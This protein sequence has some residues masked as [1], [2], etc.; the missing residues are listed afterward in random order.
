MINI[1]EN[2]SLAP[3][4]TFR[5]GGLAKYFIEVNNKEELLEALGFVR[6][7]QLKYFILGGGSNLLI[8]DKGFDGVVIKIKINEF[9]ID[10]ENFSLSIGSG[11]FL[12]KVVKESVVSGMTGMEWAAGVPGTVGGAIRGNAR[13]YGKDFGSVVESV[14]FLDVNDLKV[15]TFN[16]QECEFLYWGSIFK[17]NANLIILSTKIKLEKGDKEK[18]Q[19]EVADIIKK[20]ITVQPQGVG[21]PGSFFLNPVVT[22][23][24][25]RQEF[26]KEKGMKPK[27][28]KLPAGWI[29]EQLGLRGKKM[30]GAMISEKHANFLINTGSATAEDVVMLSSYIKQQVRDKYGIQLESEVNHVGF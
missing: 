17:K 10:Q 9:E 8:S 16:K 1:Q 4:T 18:S 14:E 30:G 22:N 20:R 27:D 13:A 6:E 5:I 3:L 2:I 24:E 12:A 19:Q 25:L 7:N 28:D 21:S 11:V 23:E 29:I 15:K 26:E